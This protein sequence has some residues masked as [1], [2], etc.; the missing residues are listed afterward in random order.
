MKTW[1]ARFLGVHDKEQKQRTQ[2]VSD[3]AEK[4]KKDFIG[5]MEKVK[6][7]TKKVHEKQLQVHQETAKLV[8]IVDDVARKIAVATGELK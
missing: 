7:Q 5:E 3:Y 4:K 8:K 2:D 1:L 6:R